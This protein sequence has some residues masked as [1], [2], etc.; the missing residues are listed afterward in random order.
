MTKSAIDK[1]YDP[2]P[3]FVAVLT[4]EGLPAPI[5]EHLFAK[6]RR[7]RFDYA[8]PA[9]LVALEV[10]GGVW[11]QGRHTRGSGFLADVLKYNTAA[12]LGWRIVRTTPKD[13]LGA[14]TL[15][16]LKSL[17]PSSSGRRE[18]TEP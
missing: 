16:M 10:E 11:T 5:Q 13:L 1:A 8:W 9:Q 7:W 12:V 6:P 3:I 2:T 17:L 4:R 14:G 15:E 18:R